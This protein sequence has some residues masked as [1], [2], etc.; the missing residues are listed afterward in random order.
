MATES[1]SSYEL[2]EIPRK[3]CLTITFMMLKK[4]NDG[5]EKVP[6][7]LLISFKKILHE[8]F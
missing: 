3:H 2:S 5:K 7:N 8:N 4:I 6:N 1:I